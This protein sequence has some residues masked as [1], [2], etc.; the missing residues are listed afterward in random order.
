MAAGGD[1]L[2]L[3]DVASIFV[4]IEKGVYFVWF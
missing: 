3:V 2:L 4:A 1:T